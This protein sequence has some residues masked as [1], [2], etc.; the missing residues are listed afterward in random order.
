MKPQPNARRKASR[1]QSLAAGLL[2]LG[3]PLLVTLG[4]LKY[5]AAQKWSEAT[6]TITSY[7]VSKGHRGYV[8]N[9]TYRYSVGGQWYESR[10]YDLFY[11]LNTG[12]AEFGKRH[13]R[14]A[15]VPCYVNPDNPQDAVLYRGV[16]QIPFAI[17][18][19]PA[20][21]FI[22]WAGVLG[23]LIFS[24]VEKYI[25][26]ARERRGRTAYFRSDREIRRK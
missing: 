7:E 14:G 13:P 5:R 3:L 1:I 23:Y 6:C 11:E 21:I 18:L 22:I 9:L 15:Q 26:R 20:I 4:V 10:Q 2:L 25:L 19:F 12:K 8:F 17:W 16:S 24:L